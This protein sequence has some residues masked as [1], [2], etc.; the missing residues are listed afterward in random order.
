MEFRKTVNADESNVQTVSPN[1]FAI[2]GSYSKIEIL[3]GSCR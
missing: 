2:D 3:D 1:E